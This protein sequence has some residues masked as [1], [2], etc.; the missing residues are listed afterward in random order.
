MPDHAMPSSAPPRRAVSTSPHGSVTGTTPKRERKRP[1]VGKVKTRLPRRSARLRT[2]SRVAE[3]ARVP[4][5]RR[6]PFHAR[7]GIGL[8]PDFSQAVSFEQDRHVEAVSQ[9]EGEIAAEHGDIGG[10]AYRVV[11]GL[12]GV[13]FAVAQGPEQVIGGRELV[14]RE[15]F[16]LHLAIGRAV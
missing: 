8:V 6:E 2:G 12:H 11:V 16:D 5:A 10:R 1:A 14:R 4:G 7:F 13:D 15:E 9:R 3:V